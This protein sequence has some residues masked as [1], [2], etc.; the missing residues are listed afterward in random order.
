[1]PLD[2]TQ[3]NEIRQLLLTKKEHLQVTSDHYSE[4]AVPPKKKKPAKTKK[5]KK[6]KKKTK[7]KRSRTKNPVEAAIAHEIKEIDAAL[8]RLEEQKERFGYCEHCFFEIP[9]RELVA[10]PARRYCSRCSS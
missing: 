7:K 2:E 3:L 5:K 9:W 6:T 4:D 10:N 1:M 8:Q